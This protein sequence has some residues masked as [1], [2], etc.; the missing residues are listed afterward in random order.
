MQIHAS[1]FKA[2][3]IRGVVPSTLNEDLALGLGRAFGS[4]AMAEGQTKVAV[5]RDG[6]LS[7]PKLS[8]ALMRGLM[9]AG[10]QVI[11]VGMV[12]TPML[13]FAAST[14][15]RSGIQVTGSHNPKDYN[16]FKMVLAGRAIFGEQ[17]QTLRRMMLAMLWCSRAQI[18]SNCSPVVNGWGRTV[19]S[20]T[21]LFCPA[22]PLTTNPPPTDDRCRS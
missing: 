3:D 4:M 1:I 10:V 2:Y 19:E 22:S 14:V 12:T 9:E 17:I 15:C 5:G 7:G 6:R 13:Y 11:D 8:A 21:M 20:A 18:C 16:G